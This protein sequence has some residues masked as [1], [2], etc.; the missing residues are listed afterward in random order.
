MSEVC[1]KQGALRLVDGHLH[2]N[3]DLKIFVDFVGIFLD[4][5]REGL[6]L[7]KVGYDRPL[8]VDHS[9]LKDLRDI[10]TRLL[11]PRLVKRLVENV[12]LGVFLVKYLYT[13]VAVTVDVLVRSCCNY[14]IKLHFFSP[15]A[16]LP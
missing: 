5:M 15:Y 11:D 9:Y 6:S 13:F 16:F 8:A 4:E 3:E 2:V 14:I 7:D 12:G 10:K 1:S